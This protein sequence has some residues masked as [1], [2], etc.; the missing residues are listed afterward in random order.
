[1]RPDDVCA[2]VPWREDKDSLGCPPLPP[3][4][5]WCV[6][7]QAR[8][9][10]PGSWAAPHPGLRVG[11]VGGAQY[12]HPPSSP[13]TMSS[14]V[15]REAPLKPAFKFSVPFRDKHA[16]GPASILVFWCFAYYQDDQRQKLVNSCALLVKLHIYFWVRFYKCKKRRGLVGAVGHYGLSCWDSSN[17]PH[18]NNLS[19]GGPRP[20]ICM[21]VS[22]WQPTPHTHTCPYKSYLAICH[23]SKTV[24]FWNAVKL[25]FFLHVKKVW[26]ISE[27]K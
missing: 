17:P 7:A 4:L 1:M 27:P 14:F 13:S 15:D 11:S 26:H 18:T 12:A 16:S 23:L 6:P 24:H 3:S 25:L 22:L 9:F 8:C 2:D 10:L 20:P 19:V 21:V 5:G